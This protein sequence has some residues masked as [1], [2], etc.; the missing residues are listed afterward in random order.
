MLC[1]DIRAVINVAPALTVCVLNVTN[2]WQGVGF[3]CADHICRPHVMVLYWLLGKFVKRPL[4]V[5]LAVFKTLNVINAA[6]LNSCV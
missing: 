3:R 5:V 2:H 4:F 1:A 6:W